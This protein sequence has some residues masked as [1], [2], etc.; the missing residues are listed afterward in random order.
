LARGVR[1]REEL[2]AGDHG[3]FASGWAR[4]RLK[5]KPSQHQTDAIDVVSEEMRELV[6]KHCGKSWL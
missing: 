4:R 5:R 6:A 1:L 2:A 3:R